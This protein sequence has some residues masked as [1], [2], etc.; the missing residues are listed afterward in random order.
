M[1]SGMG[2][3]DSILNRVGQACA[4]PEMNCEKKYNELGESCDQDCLLVVDGLP[5]ATEASQQRAEEE[6]EVERWNQTGRNLG[7]SLNSNIFC[8]MMFGGPSSLLGPLRI[9]GFL[10][11]KVYSMLLSFLR[12]SQSKR[13][14]IVQKV[15]DPPVISTRIDLS[16]VSSGWS[17]ICHNGPSPM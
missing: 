14:S 5:R 9:R 2:R 12:C 1:S 8:M 3:I 10:C 15:H 13:R 6:K 17:K 11:C 16:R 4:A 7:R